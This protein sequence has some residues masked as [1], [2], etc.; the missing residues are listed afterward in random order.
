MPPTV[1]RRGLP[2]RKRVLSAA[3]RLHQ[4]EPWEISIV[5]STTG[6]V[7]HLIATSELDTAAEPH[8]LCGTK[9]K[10]RTRASFA[11]RGCLRCCK[12]ALEGG[13]KIVVVGSDH[14]LVDLT[15]V[16]RGS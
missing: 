1:R 8:A 3:R 14:Q 15:D 10:R 11:A 16:R 13:L 6:T 7:P 2:W 5:V 9:A 12:V 4:L